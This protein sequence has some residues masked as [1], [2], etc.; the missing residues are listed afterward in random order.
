MPATVKIHYRWGISV[1]GVKC[2]LWNRYQLCAVAVDR[3]ICCDPAIVFCDQPGARR[4]AKSD[5]ARRGIEKQ[6]VAMYL[7]LDKNL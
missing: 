1:Y 2:E 4:Q 5:S 7:P 3:I 6:G